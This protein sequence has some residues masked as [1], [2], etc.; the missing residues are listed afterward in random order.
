MISPIKKSTV[1]LNNPDITTDASHKDLDE[2]V[3]VYYSDNGSKTK[4]ATITKINT[5]NGTDTQIEVNPVSELGKCYVKV[6]DYVANKDLSEQPQLEIGKD[7]V[8]ANIVYANGKKE[9]V[10]SR[11]ADNDQSDSDKD[12][13]KVNL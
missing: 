13:K 8:K 5:N 4:L 1:L 11:V 9:N 10:T 6:A 7:Y 3:S 12:T 2:T